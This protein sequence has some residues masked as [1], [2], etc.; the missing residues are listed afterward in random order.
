MQSDDFPSVIFCPECFVGDVTDWGDVNDTN[1]LEC[2]NC[3][4]RWRLTED[5]SEEYEPSQN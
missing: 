2:K 4:H 3:G 5:Q 1:E